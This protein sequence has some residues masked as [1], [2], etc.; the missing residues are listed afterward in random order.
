[1]RGFRANLIWVDPLRTDVQAA[2]SP[3]QETHSR[4]VDYDLKTRNPALSKIRGRGWLK[5]EF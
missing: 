3:L 4:T 2:H 1:M 5:G